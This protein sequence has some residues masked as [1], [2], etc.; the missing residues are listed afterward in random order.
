MSTEMVEKAA[1]RIRFALPEIAT[2][3]GEAPD[4]VEGTSGAVIEVTDDGFWG[5]VPN[6]ARHRVLRINVLSDVTRDSLGMPIADD[7][8]SVAWILWESIDSL[9]NDVG[10]EW[11]FAHTSRRAWGPTLV[12]V[13]DGDFSVMLSVGYEVSHD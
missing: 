12:N 13:P 2:Y 4:R 11:E 1:D 6:G 5:P 10:H 7:A 8:D 9:F 3:E